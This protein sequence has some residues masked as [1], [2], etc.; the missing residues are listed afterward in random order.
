V[1]LAI[2]LQ[3]RFNLTKSKTC[4]IL[5]EFFGIRL[6]PGG[7]VDLTHRM[8]SKLK[9]EYQQLLHEVQN[10]SHI[11]A[12][13]TGWY[14]GK[15]GHQLCVFTNKSVTLYHITNTRNREMVK[16]ILGDYQGVLITDCL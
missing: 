3:S 1:V 15:T 13:E 2:E 14:V 11:H 4:A 7:L 16:R 8:A 12:D 10:S 6:T 5:E 9:P